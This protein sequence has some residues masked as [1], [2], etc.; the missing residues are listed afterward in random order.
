MGEKDSHTAVANNARGQLRVPSPL[1]SSPMG[2]RIQV[3]PCTSQE[4][5]EAF[6]AGTEGASWKT[7]AILPPPVHWTGG[8]RY[9]LIESRREA[10]SGNL[11][12][13]KA[14]GVIADEDLIDLIATQVWRGLSPQAHSKQAQVP[15]VR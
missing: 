8:Y 14:L 13:L 15:S 9:N 12:I 2:S 3:I 10:A 7:Y 11:H 6:N 1:L 4:A 5:Q